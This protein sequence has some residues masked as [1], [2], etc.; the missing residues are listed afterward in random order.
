MADAKFKDGDRVKLKSG[1]PMM[2]VS[3]VS[4]DKIECSWFVDGNVQH[5]SFNAE[6]LKAFQGKSAQPA[7]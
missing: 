3:N 2:T 5:D 1:G 4:E 6:V 7:E